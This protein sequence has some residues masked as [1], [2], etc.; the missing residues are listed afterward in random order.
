[1]AITKRVSKTIEDPKEIEYLCGLKEADITTSLIME[2]FGDFKDHQAFNPYDI[3]TV[4][5]GAYGGR[6]P[7]G[8]EKRNTAPFTTTVGR[9][10]FNKYFT[11]IHNQIL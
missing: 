5:T 1:M 8:K 6:L 11:T 7:D 3:L 2:L 4:P 10:I 9:L